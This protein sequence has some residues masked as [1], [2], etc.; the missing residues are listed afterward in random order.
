LVS[1]S[2]VAKRYPGGEEALRQVSFSVEPGE[3]VFITGRSGAGKSTLLK[4]IPAIER[5][6]SGSVLVNGQNVGALRPPAIPV[7][8]RSLGLVFQDQKLLYDRSAYD[9]VMLPLAF[10]A[11]APKEAARRARAALDK[12]GLLA[13]EKANPIQLSGGEQQRLAIARAVV[14]RPSVLLADEPTANLDEES[15]RR[16]IEIF[17]EFNRVGV[18]VLIATHDE[19]LVRAYGKRLL[20]LAEGRLQ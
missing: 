19:A 12:V 10:S 2:A 11:H 7:L 17:V 6:T 18:T 5:P 3:L 9:N 13:R 1:F 15:A 8:R 14:N 20:H 4:L 16:I